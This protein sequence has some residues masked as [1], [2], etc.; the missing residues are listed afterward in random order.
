[1]CI[2]KQAQREERT[3]KTNYFCN[4]YLIFSLQNFAFLALAPSCMWLCRLEIRQFGLPKIQGA[5]CMSLL[6]ECAVFQVLISLLF[7]LVPS[8]CLQGTSFRYPCSHGNKSLFQQKWLCLFISSLCSY[9]CN[10]EVALFSLTAFFPLFI[11]PCGLVPKPLL[12][13]YGFCMWHYFNQSESRP[14]FFLLPT[15]SELFSSMLGCLKEARVKIILNIVLPLFHGRIS[16]N[17]IETANI[18][19]CKLD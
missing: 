15:Y 4:R 14:V 8:H 16:T 12:W 11:R 18:L 5:V 19:K 10:L 6:P 1:M 2:L 7:V 17:W 9:F 13:I 3:K